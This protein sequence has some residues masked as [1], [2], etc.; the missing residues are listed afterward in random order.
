MNKEKLMGVIR[1]LLTFGGGYIVAQGWLDEE[2][3]M[4][5]T[6]AA[7]TVIGVAWSYFAPEKQIS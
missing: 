5:L 1:H 2:T 4:E 3:V 6:G 7:V